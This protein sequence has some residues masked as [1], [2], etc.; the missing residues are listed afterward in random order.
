MKYLYLDSYKQLDI[1]YKII[2]YDN[3]LNLI[4]NGD[5]RKKR[6]DIII[7]LNDLKKSYFSFNSFNKEDINNIIN[8]RSINNNNKYIIFYNIK[9]YKN[10]EIILKSLIERHLYIKFIIINDNNYKINYINNFFYKIFFQLSKYDKII[11]KNYNL[12]I[13]YDQYYKKIF[14]IYDNYKKNNK[15]LINDIKEYS[16]N[17]ILINFEIKIFFYGILDFFYHK[18]PG[19]RDKIFELI[20]L[21]NDYYLNYH[22]IYRNIICLESYLIELFIIYKDIKI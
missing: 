17:L 12:D 9:W 19:K 8:T 3:H 2:K 7:L 14:Y 21:T 11:Y 15:F 16:N 1:I 5:Y 10:N 18:Y 13:D 22:K 4:I 6:E 20:H